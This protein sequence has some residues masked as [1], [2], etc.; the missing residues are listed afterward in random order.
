MYAFI[1]MILGCIENA[2]ELKNEIYADSVMQAA[3]VERD[4]D[5]AFGALYH[6]YTQRPDI[7]SVN[8]VFCSEKFINLV[9]LELGHEIMEAWTACGRGSF[10]EM[11]FDAGLRWLVSNA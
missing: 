3:F 6:L 2:Q 7:T 11:A 5:A 4:K 10:H 9:E 1:F 8:S